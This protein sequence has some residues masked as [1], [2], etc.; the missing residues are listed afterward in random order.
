MHLARRLL[1]VSLLLAGVAV[2][3]FGFTPATLAQGSLLAWGTVPSP[4]HGSLANTLDAITTVSASD[5]W[6]VGEYNPGVPPTVTGRRTLTEHWN[7]QTWSIV[8]SPNAQ[9]PG[10]QASHLRGVEALAS[11]NVWAVGYGE[12][13]ASLESQ[14]LIAHWN[15]STWNPVPSPNPAGT[16]LPNQLYAI[17]GVAANDIWA[18]GAVGYPEGPLTLHWNGTSWQAISNSCT[19]PLTGVV[20]ISSQ[21]V[22]GV[23]D[24]TSCHYNGTSW[25]RVPIALPG[26]TEISDPLLAVSASSSTDVWA[27]GERIFDQGEFFSYAPLIEHWN[28]SNWTA[29]T[30]VPGEYL[31]GVEALASNDVY[32]VGTDGA[33]PMVG[34]WDGRAWVTVP[35]PQPVHGGSLL[36]VGAVS[37]T[38]LWAVGTFYGSSGLANEGT[39]VEQAPSTT[40]GTVTG[41]TNVGGAT[42]SWFGPVNGSTATDVSGIYAAAGLP[43]GTYSI[44][45]S[46]AGCTPALATVQISA[47]TSVTQNFHLGC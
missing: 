9:F 10:V 24:T 44:T 7:G 38:N 11:N 3:L 13:F 19:T 6:T 26:G 36:A 34:H 8:P 43:A 31:N 41:A 28:G 1:A 39:L 40:Q 2:G 14:T 20:A 29:M 5:I 15:G 47:G 45:A 37:A 30:V 33:E 12:N 17:D 18:V 22:W 42:I 23:G 4:N 46:F 35:S 27:A 25:T 32:A 16:N 21:D